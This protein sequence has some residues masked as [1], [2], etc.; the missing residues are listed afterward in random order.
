[1][2]QERDQEGPRSHPKLPELLQLAQLSRQPLELIVVDLEHT[3][4]R[5]RSTQFEFR[6]PSCES[7]V[8]WPISA[9]SDVNL[10]SFT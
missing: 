8:S 7:S 5:S 4:V 10:F 9:G 2:S 1:M 6:T 3:W